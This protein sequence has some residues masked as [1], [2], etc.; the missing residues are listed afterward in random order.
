MIGFL[1]FLLTQKLTK[2]KFSRD[3]FKKMYIKNSLETTYYSIIAHTNSLFYTDQPVMSNVQQLDFLL[4]NNRLKV[5]THFNLFLFF[6]I[7]Y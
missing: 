6:L 3:E 7:L 2:S 1:K 4:C 5:T